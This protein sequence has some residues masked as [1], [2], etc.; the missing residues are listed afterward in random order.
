VAAKYVDRKGFD[1]T[2]CKYQLFSPKKYQSERVLGD[3]NL[4]PVPAETLLHFA[5]VAVTLRRGITESALL[6][7][8][9]IP[10]QSASQAKRMQQM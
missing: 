5:E 4:Q 1:A 9:Q 3:W 8:R 2:S 10:E 6:Q 7:L